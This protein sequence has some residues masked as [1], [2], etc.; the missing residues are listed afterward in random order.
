MRKL[1]PSGKLRPRGATVCLGMTGFDGGAKMDL[2]RGNVEFG[3]RASCA[4]REAGEPASPLG[5]WSAWRH[6]A[7]CA[8]GDTATAVAGQ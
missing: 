7:P 8:S 4:A 3:T 6:A 1:V 2:R 5:A